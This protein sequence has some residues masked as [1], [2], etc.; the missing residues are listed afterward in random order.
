MKCGAIFSGYDARDY[1][2]VC[3]AR[4]YDFPKEFELKTVR[5]K[6]QD[7]VG[8]CVA[9][10][11]S[12]VLE[13]YN[14][15]QNDNP[16]EMSVGY[17]Y[18]NRSTSEYKG[19][20]MIM[21]DA[22]EAVRKCGDVYKKDFCNGII[23]NVEVP[24]ATALYEM[25]KDALHKKSYPH[26]ISQ[27]CRV[28]SV[29]A[30]KASLYAGNP[31]LMAMMWYDDMEVI[32]GVLTTSYVGEAGGHCMFI[33]GW[34]ETG[35][36]VQNSWGCYD[37]STEVLTKDGFKKFAD[38]TLQDA[39]ATVDNNGTL[40]YQNAERYFEYDYSGDMYNYNNSKIDLCVTPNHNMYFR[41]KC[42]PFMLQKAEDIEQ[43]NLYFKRTAKW[44]GINQEYF[45]L[46]SIEK[47]MNAYR[48]DIVPEKKIR[49]EDFLT[50]LGYYISEGSCKV[51]DLSKYNG[52]KEYSVQISQIKPHTKAIMKE[53]LNK[54][55]FKITETSKGFVIS[56]QQ[57]WNYVK[58]LG[59]SESK[60]IPDGILEL[61][62]YYLQFLFNALMLGDG[63]STVC[64]NG[65]FRNTY[66]TSSPKLR[67]QFQE[68]CLKLGY[69]SNVFEDDRIGRVN[70]NGV[71]RFINYQIRIQKYKTSWD[72]DTRFTKKPEISQYNGKIYCVEVPNHTLFVRRNGKTCWCGNS[73]FGN[74]GCFIL[75]Y[76]M[77]VEEFWTLTD[78]IIEGTYVK[79][80]FKS[81]IGKMFA[82]ML[83]KVANKVGG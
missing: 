23:D 12:S 46:P 83:N 4:E 50:F 26:R 43:K 5:I 68:L 18:G 19:E 27:Y 17:I 2:L 29:N 54:L 49:M 71:Q 44:D 40:Q 51:S 59:Y 73:D 1:K 60:R 32:D 72:K 69:A 13:Y 82:K 45:C 66:Y 39:F 34:N 63:S 79:K 70:S 48:T 67:D 6:C 8:S 10:S 3:A 65:A 7:A 30:I 25:Q 38:C 74:N 81:K 15:E 42:K 58:D 61:S 35:W 53:N 55:P 56:N 37:D 52:G 77:P 22:L 28:N 11:L 76:E 75:P 33:Y 78:D 57:L 14:N 62:P 9:H 24:V 41:T 21:R 80:P 20:G 64:V 47:K 36:L 31:V 16:A